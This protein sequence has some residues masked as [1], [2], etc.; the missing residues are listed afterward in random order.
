MKYRVVSGTLDVEIEANTHK[1]AVIKAIDE[2]PN[3]S[4]GEIVSCL[5]IGDD[6]MDEVFMKTETVL[7][8]MGYRVELDK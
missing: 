1:L 2:H 8:H 5:K 7:N 4:L 6:E 3:S